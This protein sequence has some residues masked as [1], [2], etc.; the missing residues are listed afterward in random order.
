MMER[1]EYLG[2]KGHLNDEQKKY[3]F[4]SNLKEM[5]KYWNRLICKKATFFLRNFYIFEFDFFV[6]LVVV[7]DFL[8]KVNII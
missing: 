5:D 8:L 2:I 1:M 6:C 7:L 4:L 3:Q